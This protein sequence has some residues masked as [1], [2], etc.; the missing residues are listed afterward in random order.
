MLQALKCLKNNLK[1]SYVILYF[2]TG[3]TNKFK[4]EFS[5]VEYGDIF[6]ILNNS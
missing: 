5:G 1:P 3:A 2:V 6:L 4:K